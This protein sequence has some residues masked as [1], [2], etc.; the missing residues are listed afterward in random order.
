MSEE[1]SDDTDDFEK[2]VY[3]SKLSTCKL[4]KSQ[5]DLT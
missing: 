4:E 2:I 3:E 1:I 5:L